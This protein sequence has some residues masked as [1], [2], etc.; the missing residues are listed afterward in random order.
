MKGW[1]RRLPWNHGR[2]QT[3]HSAHT[4]LLEQTH[5]VLLHHASTIRILS[6]KCTTDLVDL[7][8]LDHSG[9]AFPACIGPLGQD[10][11]WILR[12]RTIGGVYR[13]A[14]RLQLNLQPSGEVQG[15]RRERIAH[16]G[17]T[18][19]GHATNSRTIPD[20]VRDSPAY[21]ETKG[22]HMLLC[23]LRL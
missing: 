11:A 20:R 10:L 22:P 3:R 1:S 5:V 7:L 2:R 23:F 19:P 16:H 8:M 4:P 15:R 12:H 17:D 21:S 13:R 18:C 9:D 6:Q 14:P